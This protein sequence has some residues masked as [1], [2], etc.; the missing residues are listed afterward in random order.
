MTP[1]FVCDKKYSI[2][3]TTWTALGKWHLHLALELLVSPGW[4]PNLTIFHVICELF[5]VHCK[6]NVQ[7]R[8]LPPF[9]GQ[10]ST[11]GTKLFLGKRFFTW[12]C[13]R[14]SSI[15]LKDLQTENSL[16]TLTMTT[17]LQLRTPTE[18]QTSGPISV[19][20]SVLDL[21]S[22]FTYA[23]MWQQLPAGP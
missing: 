20:P 21:L 4:S 7:L 17:L 12:Y 15:T 6:Q 10:L 22:V 14:L 9:H 8:A 11:F 1:N 23:H 16:C 13:L 18:K 3:S 2:N 5:G 19:S